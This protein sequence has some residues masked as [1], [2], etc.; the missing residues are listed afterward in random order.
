MT[1][2]AVSP[3]REPADGMAQVATAGLTCPVPAGEVDRVLLGHGSGGKLS[4]ALLRDRFLP[5]FGNDVLGELGD[6]AV[7]PVYGDEIAVSTD[8]FVVSPLEFPGG[9]IGH[10]A[11]H[12]T[13]NDLAMMGAK[14]LYLSA[15][16]ILEEGLPFDVLDRV[17]EAMTEA[18]RKRKG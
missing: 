5:R 2:D 16:F 8:S 17:L 11:V 10:L 9:N 13:V 18:I 6:A 1:E 14:P 7:V 3:E 15:G 4:A 12:G